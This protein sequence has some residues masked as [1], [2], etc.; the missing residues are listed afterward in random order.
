[1][2]NIDAISQ[3]WDDVSPLQQKTIVPDCSIHFL[4]QFPNF[5]FSFCY[6]VQLTDD[7]ARQ[8]LSL[9]GKKIKVNAASISL[10]KS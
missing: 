6:A 5:V 3:Y 9:K 10:I 2:E 4:I 1:M 7:Q 8:I